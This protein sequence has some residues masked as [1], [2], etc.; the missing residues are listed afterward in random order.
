MQVHAGQALFML[1][2]D[3]L[4]ALFQSALLNCFPQLKCTSDQLDI[5]PSAHAHYQC[6]SA[7]KWAKTL[8]MNPKEI[9]ERLKR[10]LLARGQDIIKSIEIAGPGFCNITLASSYL[11]RFLL[12][13]QWDLKR[14]APLQNQRILIDF[15]CPNIAK[16]MH[17]GHLRSTI[18]GDCLAKLMSHLGADVLRINHLGDWGTQFG[19]LIAYLKVHSIDT[20][21]DL[22]ALME[23]YQ[24]A[25]RLFDEDETF[26]RSAHEQVIALQ[27]R[28]P[29][30]LALWHRLCRIS[31]V[32]F[33][34]IYR[35]LDVELISRGESYYSNQLHPM[36]A[37]LEKR[38]KLT[39]SNGAKCIFPKGFD[40]PLMVQKS[41]GGF[42]YDT[43][44]LAALRYRVFEDRVD[45]IIYV[46]DAGQSLHFQ[47][48]FAAARQIDYLPN[49]VLVQHVPFGLVLGA[50]GK[51]FRTRSGAIIKLKSL[52]QEAVD[53]AYD[54]A[55][56]K[57]PHQEPEQLKILAH[58]LGISAVKYADL[59]TDRKQD[60]TFS[61]AKMLRFEGNTAPF[62]LYSLVRSISISRRLRERGVD[63]PSELFLEHASEIK[64]SLLLARY[65]EALMAA[66]RDLAPHRLAHHLYAIANSFNAFF[67]DCPV[68]GSPKESSRA[69]LTQLT[70]KILREGIELL[71]LI[72]VQTM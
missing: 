16:E 67:R 14:K 33:E 26:K 54:L 8:Q 39:V 27:S 29:T 24:S 49:H 10:E 11:E 6:N 22:A 58:A 63:E 32:G 38:Q 20:E 46:T 62:L 59:S 30:A 19:M 17:V 34:E 5:T 61:Y 9:A 48:L 4:R 71:G 25:K 47:I 44:D 45:E 56:E 23:I 41:D 12:Q 52:L 50:D 69:C 1:I 7:M 60:Y 70:E 72:S 42:T 18:I 66:K 40:I 31:S 28:D 21:L 57:N 55:L 65:P 3:Q 51:K 36:I 53:R 2:I 68:I 13:G 15:S 64:L 35:L 37:D 43:T